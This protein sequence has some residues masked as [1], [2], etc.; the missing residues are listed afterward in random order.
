MQ[1]T[2][3]CVTRCQ[4][5]ADEKNRAR[6]VQ[7]SSQ[8]EDWYEWCEKH[9]RRCEKLDTHTPDVDVASSACPAIGRRL[10][11]NGNARNRA[12][13]RERAQPLARCC[14]NRTR[15]ALA[16]GTRS[17]EL[18]HPRPARSNSFPR[19]AMVQTSSVSSSFSLS[20]T[21]FL[22][23][24]FFGLLPRW[25]RVIAVVVFPEVIRWQ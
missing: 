22:R 9:Q 14:R 4:T 3:A 5:G 8:S 10:R 2:F 12:D 23:G 17:G 6:R 1:L 25:G 19:T 7:A 16:H 18:H 20:Y 21:L 13:G 24:L 11:L 15:L